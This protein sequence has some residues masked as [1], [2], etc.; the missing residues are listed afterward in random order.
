VIL[1]GAKLNHKKLLAA[2]ALVVIFT[3]AAAGCCN[4]AGQSGTDTR[5]PGISATPLPLKN[6]ISFTG[7]SGTEDHKTAVSGGICVVRM[8]YKKNINVSCAYPDGSTEN[9]FDSMGYGVDNYPQEIDRVVTI[10]TPGMMTVTIDADDEYTVD[11]M[12]LPTTASSVAPPQDITGH[13]TQVVGPI[14]LD[15]GSARFSATYAGDRE[16]SM[17][18]RDAGGKDIGR[19]LDNQNGGTGANFNK[20]VTYNVPAKGIYF[21]E[22]DTVYM[23]AGPEWTLV[24]AQ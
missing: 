19:I 9:W 16:F 12:Q 7:G 15:S 21:I 3:V 5:A 17:D 2:A 10:G 24:I 22:I 23:N 6:V 4:I 18:L 14:S 20:A 8:K 1:G 11:L 13:M